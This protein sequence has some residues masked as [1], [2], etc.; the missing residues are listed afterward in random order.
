MNNVD[1]NICNT[2]GKIY[3][4]AAKLGYDLSVFSSLYLKSDFCR[5]AFDTIY[6]RFQYHDEEESWDFLYPEIK[7]RLTVYGEGKSFDGG[8]AYWIG[9]TYRQLYIEGGIS[10]AELADG[11]DF[12]TMCNYYPGLHTVDEDMAYDIIIANYNNKKS[13]NVKHSYL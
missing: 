4:Y 3:E 1:Y 9:F 8:V 11:I 7:D 6:S 13:G 5:R 12:N 10:S 2:Q